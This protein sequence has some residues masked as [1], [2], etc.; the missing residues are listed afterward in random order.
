MHSNIVV[1]FMR[2]SYNNNIIDIIN[3]TKAGTGQKVAIALLC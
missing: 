1:E 2:T 3:I